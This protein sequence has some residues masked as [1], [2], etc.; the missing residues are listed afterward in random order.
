MLIKYIIFINLFFYVATQISLNAMNGNELSADENSIFGK[1]EKKP[2]V[3]F[4]LP[5]IKSRVDT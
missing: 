1:F 2:Y 4:G 3:T 5:F